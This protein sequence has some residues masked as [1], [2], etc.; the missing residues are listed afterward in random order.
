M[1]TF[2]PGYD[3]T[4]RPVAAR[5]PRSR[6]A[7]SFPIHILSLQR[8][9]GNQAVQR[10]LRAADHETLKDRSPVQQA[11]SQSILSRKPG[12]KAEKEE[13][14]KLLAAFTGVADG[15]EGQVETIGSAMNAFSL[16]QLRAMQNAGLR[17]WDGGS[18]PPEFKDR[19]AVKNLSTPAEYVDLIHVIRIA[20]NATTDAIRHEMAHAWDH[21]RTGKVKPI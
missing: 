3:Q 19:V 1:R 9:I 4:Q 13:R 5:S 11:S 20:R 12:D 18:L 7:T 2:A 15:V 17:F 16:H 10:L 8:A 14:N 6:D 21:V